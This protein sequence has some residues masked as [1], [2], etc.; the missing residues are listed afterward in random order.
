MDVVLDGGQDLAC[1]HHRRRGQNKSSSNDAKSSSTIWSKNDRVA[2]IWILEGAKESRREANSGSG[3]GHETITSLMTTGWTRQRLVRF[4]SLL[5]FN[6]G[7]ASADVRVV[8]A[9]SRAKGAADRLFVSVLRNPEHNVVIH[10]ASPRE[11]FL[12]LITISIL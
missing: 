12:A 1:H 9:R 8:S 3:N 7:G 10:R 4:A 5:E 2:V 6:R 11:H